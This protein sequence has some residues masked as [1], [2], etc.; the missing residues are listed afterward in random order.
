MIYLIALV[1]TLAAA[2]IWIS[3]RHPKGPQPAAYGHLQTMA[4]LVDE[5]TSIMYWGDKSS[6]VTCHTGF[7]CTALPDVSMDR[8]YS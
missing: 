7:N 5:W 2:T 4:N 6:F 8:L 3:T 1:A